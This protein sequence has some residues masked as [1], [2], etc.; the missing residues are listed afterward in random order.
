MERQY[1]CQRQSVRDVPEN[2]HLHYCYPFGR[3]AWAA[4]LGRCLLTIWAFWPREEGHS[5]ES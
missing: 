1:G 3:M 2:E 5:L 4:S